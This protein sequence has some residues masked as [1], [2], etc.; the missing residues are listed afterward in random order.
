ML[1]QQ[2]CHVTQ[3]TA[4]YNAGVQHP[5]AIVTPVVYNIP[6]SFSVVRV[7]HAST[8]LHHFGSEFLFAIIPDYFWIRVLTVNIFCQ[9]IYYVKQRR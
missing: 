3:S 2:T 1:S 5:T 9:Y 7:R 8:C 4:H 6:G